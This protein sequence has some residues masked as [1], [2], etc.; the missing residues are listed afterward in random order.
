MHKESAPVAQKLPPA[1][2]L[3][4]IPTYK[5]WPESAQVGCKALQHCFQN[6]LVPF[7]A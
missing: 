4:S 6:A 2:V 3:A 5:E 1:A 7:V